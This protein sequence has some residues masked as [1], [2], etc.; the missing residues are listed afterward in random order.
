M[1]FHGLGIGTNHLDDQSMFTGL[2]LDSFKLQDASRDDFG[3]IVKIDWT[4]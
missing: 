4:T 2:E 3:C 1:A